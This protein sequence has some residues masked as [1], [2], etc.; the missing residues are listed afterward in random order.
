MKAQSAI[1]ALVGA[2][3][4]EGVEASGARE[5]FI[6]VRPTTNARGSWTQTSYGGAARLSLYI[7]AETIAKSRSIGAA[8]LSAYKQFS[9]TLTDHTVQYTE[10]SNARTLFGPGNE[11]RYLVD[12]VFHY[13]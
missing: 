10:V 8:I 11:F 1:S 5:P 4:Y 13:T 9:G 7:H 6:V 12:L 2:R 3:V